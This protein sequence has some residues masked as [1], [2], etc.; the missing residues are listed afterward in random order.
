VRSIKKKKYKIIRVRAKT[1][2]KRRSNWFR[3]GN[4]LQNFSTVFLGYRLYLTA[5][6][7]HLTGRR[8]TAIYRCHCYSTERII[9][10][11][12]YFRPLKC[13]PGRLSWRAVSWTTALEGTS[14]NT[15]Y[16]CS[17]PNDDTMFGRIFA[18]IYVQGLCI[19]TYT[20]PNVVTP[21]RVLRTRS[22]QVTQQ[23]VVVYG[24]KTR[25]QSR[26]LRRFGPAFDSALGLRCPDV[27][28][29]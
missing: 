19:A 17:I 5:V 20:H 14:T 10:L 23:G 21:S 7:S 4:N 25:K 8:A 12:L 22:S 15:I 18:V 6:L 1:S 16:L 3:C 26:K 27:R 24:G 2:G 11:Y 9:Q 28:W 29:T 13:H